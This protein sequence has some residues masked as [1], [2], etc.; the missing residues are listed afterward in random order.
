[1]T[2]RKVIHPSIG[3]T[4]GSRQVQNVWPNR[5]PHKRRPHKPEMSDSMWGYFMACCGI[6]KFMVQHDVLWLRCGR[7]F[8]PYCGNFSFFVRALW[9]V[10]WL[11]VCGLDVKNV[12]I[13]IEEGPIGL[14]S[15]PYMPYFLASKC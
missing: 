1:L 7:A 14:I 12:C 3:Y 9:S 11:T 10:F 8:T 4:G 13:F 6:Q 5:D 2:Q 15:V